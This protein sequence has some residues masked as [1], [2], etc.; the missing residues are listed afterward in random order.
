VRTAGAA[1]AVAVA[2]EVRSRSW[3]AD[4]G[5]DRERFSA[6]C[7]AEGV[8]LVTHRD[9]EPDARAVVAYEEEKGPGFSM[10]GIG[11]PVGFGTNI[12][13]TLQLFTAGVK[14]ARFTLTASAGTPPGRAAEQFHQAAR[15]AFDRDPA[16]RYACAAIAAALGSRSEALKLLPFAALDSRGATL[17]DQ[18]DFTAGTITEQAYVAVARHD[19]SRLRG[20]DP[21]ARLEPLLLLFANSA[22][23]RNDIALYPATLPENAAFLRAVL[24]L[25]ASSGDERAAETLTD[26]LSDYADYRDTSDETIRPLLADV[27]RTLGQIGNSFT[28]PLLESWQAG[29]GALV[30]E[31]SAAAS[32]LKKR[33][34]VD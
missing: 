2:L 16:F 8:D 32:A 4:S 3:V 10:F 26:F 31:A 19:V 18:I 20:L 25:V 33:L 7:R 30:H 14:A 5:F 24:P 1:D 22:V 12:T 15:E 21:Q 27:L 29:G 13:F 17:L 6:S 23:P 34:G 11:A 9:G 28:L